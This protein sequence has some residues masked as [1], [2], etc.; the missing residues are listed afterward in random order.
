MYTRGIYLPLHEF[1]NRRDT[2][3]RDRV[4][5]MCEMLLPR[6][7]SLGYIVSDVDF[8][9]EA[10]VAERGGLENSSSR[11]GQKSTRSSNTNTYLSKRRIQIKFQINSFRVIKMY[12]LI[13]L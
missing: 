9:F 7:P 11:H 13:E 2:Y 3:Y 4:C 6:R 8:V 1:R 5:G 12:T 10:A